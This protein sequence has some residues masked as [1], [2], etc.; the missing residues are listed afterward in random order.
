VG[1]VMAARGVGREA[2]VTDE[3]SF[4]LFERLLERA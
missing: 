3:A 2:L 1:N 4:R